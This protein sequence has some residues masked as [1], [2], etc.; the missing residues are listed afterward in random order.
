M[1]CA[2]I[3]APAKIRMITTREISE[4]LSN[5]EFYVRANDTKVYPAALYRER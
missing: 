5:L 2:L 1:Q 4:N 3:E